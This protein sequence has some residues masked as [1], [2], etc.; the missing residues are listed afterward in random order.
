MSVFHCAKRLTL[1]ALAGHGRRLLVENYSR[2]FDSV[3][4][5]E[6][7]IFKV[8]NSRFFTFQSSLTGNTSR[9]AC[10]STLTNRKFK[11]GQKGRARPP[12]GYAGVLYCGLLGF[13]LRELLGETEKETPE[14]PEDPPLTLMIKRGILAFHLGEFDKSERLLHLALKTAQEL[15]DDKA[16]TFIFDVLANLAFQ[17]EDYEK[18]EKLFKSV[19]QRHVQDGGDVYDNVFVA[20]SLKLAHCFAAREDYNNAIMGFHYCIASQNQKIRPSP[21]DPSVLPA[22]TDTPFPA[23]SP[24]D[25]DTLILWA[26]SLEQY[27]HLLLRIGRY[28]PA[29]E[30]LQEALA[31][32]RQ[33]MGD[34]HLQTAVLRNDIGTIYS[35]EKRYDEAA[36]EIQQAINIVQS[37][38]Q[39]EDERA[40]TELEESRQPI[41]VGAYPIPHAD[42][43][44]GNLAAYHI[45]LGSVQL[46]RGRLKSARRCCEEGALVA[47]HLLDSEGQ[48]EAAKCLRAIKEAVQERAAK[49]AEREAAT[50]KASV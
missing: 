23:S 40:E 16:V 14:E 2:K 48:K 18:A 9:A 31:V 19:L 32:C 26:M 39:A 11:Q 29:R 7:S 17:R 13:S 12:R 46:L 10:S 41:K 15:E 36:E 4:K 24:P 35:M 6:N 49:R 1:S 3:V 47:R 43:P 38:I 27:A 42:N 33:V 30:Q 44:Q 37:H 22:S 20:I 28:Q 34:T 21:D 5:T 8:L 25:H 45:N 50:L